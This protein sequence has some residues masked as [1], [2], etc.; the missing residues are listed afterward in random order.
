MDELD[1]QTAYDYFNVRISGTPEQ[2]AVWMIDWCRE[3]FRVYGIVP[4]ITFN[5]DGSVQMVEGIQATP[6]LM[7]THTFNDAFE[8]INGGKTPDQLDLKPG[9]RY[10][11]R[12]QGTYDGKWRQASQ[13]HDPSKDFTTAYCGAAQAGEGGY[14]IVFKKN[15]VIR[16]RLCNNCAK[17]IVTRQ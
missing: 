5:E 6:K 10:I 17:G 9:F 11:H 3:A 16:A 15:Q 4:R 14:E 12:M 2:F 1:Q 7:E 13:Y 8:I